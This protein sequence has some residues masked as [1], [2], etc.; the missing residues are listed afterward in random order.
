MTV[1]I[2]QQTVYFR[3]Q[4]LNNN[5][6]IFKYK[7]LPVMSGSKQEKDRETGGRTDHEKV[8][9]NYRHRSNKNFI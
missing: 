1:K 9:F 6:Y 8:H 2:I 4:G 5:I 7:N 3:V